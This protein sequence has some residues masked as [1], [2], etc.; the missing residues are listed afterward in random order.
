LG[1]HRKRVATDAPL[2]GLAWYTRAGWQR[3]RGLAADR[4]ALG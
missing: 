4:E 2:V 1:T 3:L